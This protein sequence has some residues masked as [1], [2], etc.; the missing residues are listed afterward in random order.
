MSND[1]MLVEQNA[2][3][4]LP[5]ILTRLDLIPIYFALIFGSYG[6]AQMASMGWAAIPM[7]LLATIV[8][9]VPCALAAYELGTLFPGEGGIY[10]WAHK[11]FGP[12]HGFISG[13][14]S[15]VP[16]LL[17]LPLGATVTTAHIQ[18][19][20]HVDWPEWLN[21]A[22]QILLIW[23]EIMICT[24]SLKVSQNFVR[25]GFFVS[26]STALIVF[27]VGWLQPVSATPITSE[28][29][30]INIFA[31]GALFSAAVLWLIGVEMP[32]TMG[33]EYSQHR[34]TAKTMLLWGTLALT[35]GYLLGITGILWSIPQSEVDVTKGVAQAVSAHY[36][37]LG[38]MVAIAISLAISSQAIAYTNAYSR[39]L[40]VSALEK[41][42]PEFLARVN[43]N[44]V[45]VHAMIVQ[46]IGA[47]IILLIFAS[48][49]TLA[50][51]V[52]LYLA[53]LVVIWCASL[54]YIYGSL[55]L[56]RKKY[57]ELYQTRDA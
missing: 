40:F 29:T 1:T 10:I 14:L 47:S 48:Q 32:F 49:G 33:A 50:V 18:A 8:F 39:L 35:V 17:L 23:I 20:F 3:K 25:L 6:A 57:K 45:P 41:R 13:W 38:S 27:I 30:D 42:L 16:I 43:K 53:S 7:L 11:T 36:P 9:L 15:W 46:G 22:L 55:I 12:I 24:R 56:A 21:V 54:Y 44:K 26:F 52:N 4:I 2:P 34:K 31:H 37:L 5:R 28:I 19:A 51:V